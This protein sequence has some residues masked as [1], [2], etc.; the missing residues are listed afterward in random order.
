MLPGTW[1]VFLLSH[2]KK[3]YFRIIKSLSISNKEERNGENTEIV[4]S[5][6]STLVACCEEESSQ[7]GERK[8]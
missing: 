8:R 4:S 1:C 3:Q 6:S 2:P 5:S 7:R